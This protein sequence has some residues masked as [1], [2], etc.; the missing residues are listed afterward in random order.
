MSSKDY[1]SISDELQAVTE[2]YH[3]ARVTIEVQEREMNRIWAQLT[4]KTNLAKRYNK[5]LHE[6]KEEIESLKKALTAQK[7]LR[8]WIWERHRV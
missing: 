7:N 1:Q 3:E 2:R 4:Q 5:E 8:E 6:A